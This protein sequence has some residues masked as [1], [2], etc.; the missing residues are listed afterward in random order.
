M[1]LRA[2]GNIRHVHDMARQLCSIAGSGTC[3]AGRC[4]LGSGRLCARSTGSAVASAPSGTT[5]IVTLT[6][7]RTFSI[8]VGQL[9]Q[10]SVLAEA[11]GATIA[12]VMSAVGPVPSRVPPVLTARQ[13]RPA[14]ED[15]PVITRPGTRPTVT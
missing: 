13:L 8:R 5:R 6:L 1:R 12:T 15:D 3:R 2:A 14:A 7:H 10:P 4:G 11:S 9:P